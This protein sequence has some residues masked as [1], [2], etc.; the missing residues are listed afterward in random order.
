MR[1]SLRLIQH[2]FVIGSLFLIP[3][4][5]LAA[6]EQDVHVSGPNY[7]IVR[8]TG[9][10]AVAS[11]TLLADDESGVFFVNDA[12]QS[13][14]QLEVDFGSRPAHCASPQMKMGSDGVYR[15]VEALKPNQ[16]VS[17]CFPFAGSYSFKATP[18]SG[19]GK[20]IS[21]SVVVKR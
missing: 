4:S 8:L 1:Y 14:L 15:S 7:K 17:I 18:E 12:S 9:A 2:S 6:V 20:V 21:G 11:Q 5:A 19:S 10:E 13:N 16:F 3:S